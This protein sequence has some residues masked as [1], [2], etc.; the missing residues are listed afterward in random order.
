MTEEASR[1][2]IGSLSM[3]VVALVLVVVGILL[4]RLVRA[5]L[6]P[7]LR[8]QPMQFDTHLVWKR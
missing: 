7:A 1:K 6:A 2:R 8:P 3:F 5:A 4:A